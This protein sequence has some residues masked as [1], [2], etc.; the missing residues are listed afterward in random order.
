[1]V[2]ANEPEVDVADP[3]LNDDDFTQLD[4]RKGTLADELANIANAEPELIP[5][6]VTNVEPV[7]EVNEPAPAPAPA[8]E[9][10]QPE[11]TNFADG[12]S[13]TL[14]KT[15]KGWKATC[16]SGIQGVNAE[17]FYGRTKDELLQNIA[18]GK[19]NSTK[20]IREL[21]RAAKIA[22]VM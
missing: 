19:I 2:M 3:W 8:P 21:N 12:S 16:E 17:V 15:S 20:K 11:V 13:L 4:T 14:E 5:E 18:A 22:K 6:V 9:P 10:P 7:Q 1:M